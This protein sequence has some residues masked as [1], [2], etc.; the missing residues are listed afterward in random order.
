M[1]RPGAYVL[2][3]L[4]ASFFEKH[5]SI[6][7]PELASLTGSETA[8]V[9]DWAKARRI[10]SVNDGAVERYP[11]FQI[12]EGQPIPQL[13]DVLKLLSA[14]LSA[15]QIAFWFT[16][17]NAWTGSWRVPADI[18]VSEPKQVLEAARHE[19]ADQIL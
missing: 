9:H 8:H 2:E 5:R 13:V 19:V 14:K 7:A 18:L 6:A 3:D 11:F 16:V 4:K 17:P 12:R 15:W 1:D 10:F